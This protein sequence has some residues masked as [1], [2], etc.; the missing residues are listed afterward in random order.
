MI[1]P[2]LNLALEQF[3]S[4]WRYALGFM[5]NAEARDFVLKTKRQMEEL[6]HKHPWIDSDG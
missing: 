5:V 6:A 3:M 1:T 2:V 4:E